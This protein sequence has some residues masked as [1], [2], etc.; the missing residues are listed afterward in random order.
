MRTSVALG[1]SM[2]MVRRAPR[3]RRRVGAQPPGQLLGI[4]AADV[5]VVDD[6]VADDALGIDDEQ[7][8]PSDA[9][10]RNQ[11]AVVAALSS[12]LAGRS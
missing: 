4:D 7:R 6:L 1:R 10:L 8:T 11:H 5:V 2:K 3:L 9:L 12:D